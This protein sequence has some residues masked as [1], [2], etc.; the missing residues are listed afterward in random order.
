VFGFH[1]RPSPL[2]D[3]LAALDTAAAEGSSRAAQAARDIRRKGQP[4]IDAFIAE[5]ATHYLNAK[6]LASTTDVVGAAARYDR[7]TTG[8]DWSAIP[9]EFQR[10]RMVPSAAQIEERLHARM[11]DAM[12]R[13]QARANA[14]ALTAVRS[15]TDDRRTR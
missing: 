10:A 6:A 11:A 1:R 13:N 7:E 15:A 2:D 12:K 14:K 3:L 9:S 4:A 8:G 5:A